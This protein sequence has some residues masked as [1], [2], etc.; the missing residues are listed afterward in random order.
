[1]SRGLTAFGFDIILVETVGVG[2]D[3]VAVRPVV[4]ALA[5]LV[6][7]NTG[8]EIQ[9][10]KAGLIELADVVVVN[11]QDIAGSD[12]VKAQLASALSLSPAEETPPIVMTSATQNKG[13][14]EMWRTIIESID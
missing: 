5:L 11:K 2:Q 10:E 12:R 6:T 8:D 7:P 13:I 1:M 14:E 4:D 3:Q 9:W